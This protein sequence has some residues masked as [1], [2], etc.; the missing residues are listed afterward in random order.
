MHKVISIAKAAA[1]QESFQEADAKLFDNTGGFFI[2]C[3]NL[4][5]MIG[6]RT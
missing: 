3:S 1:A 5:S 4:K 6:I 2:R